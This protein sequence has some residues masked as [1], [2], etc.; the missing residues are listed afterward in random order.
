MLIVVFFI[1]ATYTASCVCILGSKIDNLG[2]FLD[3]SDW[4]VELES[5]VL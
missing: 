1:G 2:L 5:G 4:S 3:A